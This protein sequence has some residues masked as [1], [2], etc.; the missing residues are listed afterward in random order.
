MTVSIVFLWGSELWGQAYLWL[1]CLNLVLFL[2]L[3]CLVH[4]QSEGICLV[5]L[6]LTLSGWLLWSL[7]ILLFSE[8]YREG[9]NLGRREGEGDGGLGWFIWGKKL[10]STERKINKYLF[11]QNPQMSIIYHHLNLMILISW[12]QNMV[13]P[14]A[15]Q[16]VQCR[17]RLNQ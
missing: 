13:L 10:F 4:P 11:F 7:G 5:L 15:R 2:L 14:V 16:R 12:H 9:M 1:F 6:Y 17:I 8:R 3:C